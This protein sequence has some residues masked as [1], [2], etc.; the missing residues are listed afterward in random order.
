M[1]HGAP[2]VN[3]SGRPR[4]GLALSEAIREKLDPFAVV[5]LVN[6]FLADETVPLER[7]LGVL[8]PWAHAGYLR[9]PTTINANVSAEPSAAHDL[10]GLTDDELRERLEWLRGRRS[11]TA[12]PDQPTVQL[13][14]L[15]AA[16]SETP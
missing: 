7:R 8:L 11:L 5:E 13:R 4:S 1:R 12:G 9:P 3:P 14:Q 16:G 2:S 10:D 6:R 15:E